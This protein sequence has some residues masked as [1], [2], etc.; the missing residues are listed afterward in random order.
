MNL[1]EFAKKNPTYCALIFISGFCSGI[2]AFKIFVEYGDKY[3]KSTELQKKYIEINI[4]N[5]VMALNRDLQAKNKKMVKTIDVLRSKK[6]EEI[7]KTRATI[8]KELEDINNGIY[9]WQ[10]KIAVFKPNDKYYNEYKSRIERDTNLAE[11]KIKKLELLDKQ[12]LQL[13]P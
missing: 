5:R 11:I 6:T 7:L 13:N 12:I 9:T 4:Y 10:K 2:G 8:E 1:I 3:I